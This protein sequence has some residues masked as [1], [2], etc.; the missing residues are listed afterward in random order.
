MC[1]YVCNV[2]IE[3][4]CCVVCVCAAKYGSENNRIE[5]VF[6]H[7]PLL[8]AINYL[9]FDAAQKTVFYDDDDDNSLASRL[10]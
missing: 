2:L 10:I 1:T 9:Y 4:I 6:S 5:I 8:R 7:I 3:L